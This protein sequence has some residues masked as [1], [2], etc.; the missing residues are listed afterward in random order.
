MLFVFGFLL[1]VLFFPYV[2]NGLKNAVCRFHN[3]VCVRLKQ[4]KGFDILSEKPG[5]QPVFAYTSIL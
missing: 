3:H 4:P 5:V 1:D 2:T